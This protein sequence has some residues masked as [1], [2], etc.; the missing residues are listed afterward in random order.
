MKQDNTSYNRI[1]LAWDRMENLLDERM[2]KKKRR[3]PFWMFWLFGISACGFAIALIAEIGSNSD[4]HE[5]II[6]K[7]MHDKSG[8]MQ[9]NPVIDEEQKNMNSLVAESDQLS[10]DR[11]NN[12]HETS[13]VIEEA[14]IQKTE[15]TSDRMNSTKS[16]D[17]KKL[18]NE[19]AENPQDQKRDLAFG[20]S[21]IKNMDDD[22]SPEIIADTDNTIEGSA[23]QSSVAFGES[24]QID[25]EESTKHDELRLEDR[26]LK[27]AYLTTENSQFNDHIMK[28]PFV[29]TKQQFV[30]CLACDHF[31]APIVS[32]A[33]EP[34]VKRSSKFSFGLMAGAEYILDFESH[35][36][37]AGLGADYRLSNRF[38][39]T[40]QVS[41]NWHLRKVI[42]NS[43]LNL[44]AG[45]PETGMDMED[46]N[47]TEESRASAETRSELTKDFNDNMNSMRISVA[48]VYRPVKRFGVF[49]GIGI[50]H[51]FKQ[52]NIDYRLSDPAA[53]SQSYEWFTVEDRFTTPIVT[54]G[55]SYKILNRISV[56][57]DYSYA[58]SDYESSE[59]TVLKT[60]KLRFGINYSF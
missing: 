52:L 50:E 2:P 29:N 32:Q 9:I 55:L 31:K 19:S 8:S 17:L 1:D 41:Y 42:D 12:N 60:D 7:S 57:A 44:G 22:E 35:G 39:L 53:L 40:G 59:F 28:I 45:M 33:I 56:S 10:N 14:S 15:N 37:Y 4:S 20:E 27:P 24:Q 26:S 49:A 58:I 30:S 18:Q 13:T 38:S 5:L 16:N 54:F 6:E 25:R 48:A 21:Q 51:Y 43:I 34:L 11:E 3:Y 36:Y 23:S 47:Q 46:S